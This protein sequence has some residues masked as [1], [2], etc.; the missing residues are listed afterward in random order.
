M[1]IADYVSCED[2]AQTIV[3]RLLGSQAYS[4]IG[5]PFIVPIYTNLGVAVPTGCV[6]SNCTTP[7]ALNIVPKLIFSYKR[8]GGVFIQSM[9]IVVE[10]CS[11]F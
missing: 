7:V 9:L 10:H 6:S 11:P 8:A 4:T 3:A 1:R 5:H 2:T